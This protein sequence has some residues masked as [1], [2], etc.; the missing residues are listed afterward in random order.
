[1]FSWRTR[2]S[3]SVDAPGSEPPAEDLRC[4]FCNKDQNDVRKL[5]AGPTVF[6]CDECV[7]I[8][9]DIIAD[10]LR[11]QGVPHDSA[12]ALA[13]ATGVA[14]YSRRRLASAVCVARLW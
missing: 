11:Q 4:S 3:K 5:I 1:M 8:C 13:P 12:E 6:I 10:N 14:G 9:N 7:E 2:K